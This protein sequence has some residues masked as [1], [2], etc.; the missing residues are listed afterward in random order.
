MKLS[1]SY[2]ILTQNNS[3]IDQ[4]VQNL[5][6]N[7]AVPGLTEFQQLDGLLFS[8][9][10]INRY[11]DEEERHDIKILTK[12]SE[13][14]LKTMSS[15]E[16][17]K[18][19]LNFLLQQDPDFIILVNPY[20]NLDV[21]TQSQLKEQ[22]QDIA[23][24]K[25]VVQLV[26]R[27]DDILP[28]TAHFFKLDGDNLH[29]YE[30]TDAF[31]EENKTES[32]N[33]NGTIPPPL[34]PIS[35]DLKELVSFKK[36]SVSFDGRKVLD[37]IDWTI[38][39]GEFWQLIGPNGSGKSTLLSMIT[40]DS[41]KGY[42]EDL[43]IFGQKKGSGESVWDLKQKIGYY[44][45]A[46]TNKFRGYHTLENMIISGLHDSIGLYVQPTDS[47]KQLAIQWL[48]LLNLKDRKNDHFRDLSVG[49]KRL[50][51]MARAMVKHPPL[52]IL[53]EPT[54]GLD[55]S[56]ANLFVALVNKIAKESDSTIVFVSHR[57]E[58]Q[59][60]PEYIFELHPSEKG[61]KGVASNI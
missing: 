21:A 47:E 20:D 40:G 27:L 60:N 48:N 44:T 7:H 52:L 45:P 41:H 18:A 51:M 35:I 16:Q 23:S 26:S 59:L 57:K 9:S 12:D 50:V 19:L 43:T 32:T 24:N 2:V 61:S 13:Q 46:I 10:E 42:G 15:G 1:K 6:R 30:S 34:S 39:K 5:L 54:A 38:K 8:R 58:P 31:W 53:D 17:K 33:F 3:N 36:V 28:D 49:N 55:D 25:I 14:A 37:E 56:S 11:M 29:P 22:L 4:L